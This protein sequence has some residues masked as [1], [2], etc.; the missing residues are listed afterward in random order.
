MSGSVLSI[1]DIG[2]TEM[3]SSSGSLLTEMFVGIYKETTD[4]KLLSE[5]WKFL[6]ISLS[7]ILIFT[8]YFLPFLYVIKIAEEN[9][10]DKELSA[11]IISTI[12]NKFNQIKYKQIQLLIVLSKVP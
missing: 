4:F 12:G 3:K 11:Y 7:N 10:I 8:G 2:V 1:K 6:L 5:N 9:N